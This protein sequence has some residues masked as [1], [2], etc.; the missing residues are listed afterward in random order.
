MIILPYTWYLYF[1]KKI[2]VRKN[3]SNTLNLYNIS[4]EYLSKRLSNSLKEIK[5]INFLFFYN[6][7]IKYILSKIINSKDTNKVISDYLKSIGITIESIK[8]TSKV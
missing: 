7:S 8:N 2:F 6:K 4:Y 1:F 3:D 5:L